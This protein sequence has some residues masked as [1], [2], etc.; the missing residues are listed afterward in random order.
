LRHSDF[1]RVY[2]LGRRH[3]SVSMN[4]FY[5]QRDPAA[6]NASGLRVGFTVGR[7]LGGAVERNRIKRRM[8][9]AVRL[10][11]PPQATS[12][13]ADI[14]INPKKAVLTADFNSLVNELRQS[15]VALKEKLEK[16]P[17]LK[18]ANKV[19]AVK[20]RSAE[21]QTPKAGSRKPIQ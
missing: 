13:D 21:S 3:F 4:L 9:E 14:V 2:K 10:T 8:R 17:Q 16:Q 19:I 18:S 6:A 15:F 1:E 12:P 11:R 7:V 20:K 5:L